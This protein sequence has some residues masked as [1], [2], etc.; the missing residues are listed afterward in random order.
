M[1]ISTFSFFLNHWSFRRNFWTWVTLI[2]IPLMPHFSTASCLMNSSSRM[3]HLFLVKGWNGWGSGSLTHLLFLLLWYK[4][5]IVSEL[6]DF[7]VDIV[8]CNTFPV[9][10]F[11][12]FLRY[13][14][15][16]IN[17]PTLN[18]QFG[19]I[20]NC[21]QLCNQ[22]HNQVTSI[23]SN[24]LLPPFS[25]VS[26][27]TP[28]YR[29]PLSCNLSPYFWLLPLSIMLWDSSILVHGPVICSFLLLKTFYHLEYATISFSKY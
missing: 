23:I 4:N 22:Y 17:C 2:C 8:W 25:Q 16:A 14:L 20:S 15:C 27:S 29:Q 11:L 6:E 9:C 1:I 12:V 10:I 7:S 5:R 24:V 26:P 28:G 18:V 13:N 3:I 19:S 21:I